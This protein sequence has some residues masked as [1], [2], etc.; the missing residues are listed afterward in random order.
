[1][2]PATIMVRRVDHS[3]AS[4][5]DSRSEELRRRGWTQCISPTRR[6]CS[7]G[8]RSRMSSQSSRIR[9]RG[10]HVKENTMLT[11]DCSCSGFRFRMF[12]DSDHSM[13]VRPL[14]S[15][16][17]IPSRPSHSSSSVAEEED[18]LHRC[19]AHIGSSS[20]GSPTFSSSAGARAGA[21]SSI[22][23]RST[24]SDAASP[25]GLPPRR[26]T[27]SA[28]RRNRPQRFLPPLL[29]IPTR[30][31]VSRPRSLRPGCTPVD[32]RWL[33]MTAKYDHRDPSRIFRHLGMD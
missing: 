6:R 12:T 4:E 8:L 19:A 24:S 26:S 22:G 25:A 28:C 2:A 29:W 30:L 7:T 17:S 20:A 21:R 15:H 18:R 3:I 5:S 31:R 1:M 14:L 27:L 9:H 16:P 32:R 13:Q 10:Q 23:R 33:Q 11:R